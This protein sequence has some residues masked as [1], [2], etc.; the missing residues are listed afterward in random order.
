MV[1]VSGSPGMRVCDGVE[2][3]EP[4]SVLLVK[5]WSARLAVMLELSNSKISYGLGD[6]SKQKIAPPVFRYHSTQSCP[7]LLP[8]VPTLH[9]LAGCPDP[10]PSQPCLHG[11]VEGRTIPNRLPTTRQP[12]LACGRRRPTVYHLQAVYLVYHLSA[13]EPGERKAGRACASGVEHG[14]SRAEIPPCGR[15]VVDEWLEVDRGRP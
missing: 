10:V 9:P 14:N 7:K 6:R 5:P 8:V 4:V 15:R 2:R 11:G 1:S 3:R 13:C 12:W